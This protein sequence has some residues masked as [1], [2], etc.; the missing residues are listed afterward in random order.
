MPF[1]F[2]TWSDGQLHYRDDNDLYATQLMSDYFASFVRSHD[3]NPSIDY[4]TVRGYTATLKAAQNSTWTSIDPTVQNGTV[5]LMDYPTSE[6][7]FID[8]P[9]CAFLQYPITY[10]L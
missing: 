8:L 4:L 9:Q 2:G 1:V 3:P 10:Y 5:R 7:T 6:T